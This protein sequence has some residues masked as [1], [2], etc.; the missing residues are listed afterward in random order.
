MATKVMLKK[1]GS[2]RIEGDFELLDGE[3]NNIDL[4]GKPG[5]SLC[6][7]AS[8]ANLPY[9]DGSHKNCGFVSEPVPVP[10]K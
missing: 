2:I 3:G 10:E 6:R 1:N 5:V 4:A 9:C 8:S 7:C